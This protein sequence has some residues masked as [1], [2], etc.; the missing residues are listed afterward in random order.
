MP[1][2]SVQSLEIVGT[3]SAGSPRE[4]DMRDTERVLNVVQK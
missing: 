4:R 3:G 2:V 1:D